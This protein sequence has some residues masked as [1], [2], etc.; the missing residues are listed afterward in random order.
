VNR[1]KPSGAFV[2][3][4][5]FMGVRVRQKTKGKGN[6]WWVFISHNGKRTSRKVGDKKAAEAVASTIRAKLQLG[7]FGFEDTKPV[8]TFKEHAKMWLA[9]PHDWK[10]STRENYLCN[11]NN[12][13]FPTFGSVP[14]DKIK[15]KGLKS[16]FDKLLSEGVASNTVA[17]IRSPIGGVLSHA[18]DSELIENNPIIGLKLIQKKTA[19]EIEPLSKV[20]NI[21]LLENAQQYEGGAF[22]HPFCAL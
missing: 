18:L 20:D 2:L 1:G 22:I 5:G 16:F 14:I 21:L 9:L 12:H 10:E 19:L 11:L 3:K 6:P 13:I 8:P 15:R 4:G 17:L 7:E